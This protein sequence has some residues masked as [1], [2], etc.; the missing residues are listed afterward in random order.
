MNKFLVL[1]CL[2]VS[3]LS[4]PQGGRQVD[5]TYVGDLTDTEHD[6]GGKVYIL[7]Q[8]TLVIDEF[9]YDGNGFGVYINVATKGRNVRGYAKIGSMFHIL[10]AQRVNLLK[11]STLVMVS[12]S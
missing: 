5:V 8:D 9:S 4:S 12:W 2:A 10:P 7:D 11:T 6:V 3:A 1:L